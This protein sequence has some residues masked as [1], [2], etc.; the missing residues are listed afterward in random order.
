MNIAIWGAGE[1]G[2]YVMGQL[3]YK[4]GLHIGC[5]IDN[6]AKGCIAGINIVSPMEYSETYKTQTDCVLV[7]FLKG[8]S[9]Q[10]Q[11][12]EM[13][14]EKWGIVK[15]D[16]FT[17]KLIL[18]SDLTT[19]KNIMWNTDKELELPLME[20]LETN[21]VDYCNLNCKGCSHFS[22]IFEKGAQV[23]YGIFER[24]IKFLSEKIYVR[25][26]NLLGGEVFLN[27]RIL[28]YIACLE[29]Y[30]PKTSIVLVTNGLLIP[31]LDKEILAGLAGHQVEISITEYPPTLRM[32]D[33]IR[34]TL[35][36][37]HISHSFRRTVMTFGKNID[38][39][40]MNDAQ[41]AQSV[42]REHK[43]QFLRDG[44]IYKC[45][46]SALGN[47]FFDYYD[48]PFHFDEGIDIYNEDMDW[49]E[50]ICNL[51]EKPIEMCRYCGAEERFAWEV[52]THP[53]KE[54]WLVA[55][56]H[57]GEQIHG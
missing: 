45:P 41:K 2:K 6:H 29:Q 35:E 16:V 10:D 52:S 33:Q 24:D 37:Y 25:R 31:N 8:I 4:E 44:K 13:G 27:S 7:A 15:D 38:L 47:H 55:T 32:K 43:C 20:T 26:F 5:I 19:D 3:R 53:Q 42:C 22:N 54:D 50:T 12:L 51:R 17:K 49:K 48:I 1:F 36:Q 56:G 14:I 23:S 40:G 57:E 46:F 39:S 21:V 9:I 30:M 11:L 18:Q 34:K 28:D